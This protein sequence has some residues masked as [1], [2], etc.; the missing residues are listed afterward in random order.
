VNKVHLDDFQQNLEKDL[1][2]IAGPKKS[3]L[4]SEFQPGNLVFP[5]IIPRRK[6]QTADGQAR[7]RHQRRRTENNTQSMNNSYY[8]PKGLDSL[9]VSQISM[10]KEISVD[11]LVQ[12][13][14]VV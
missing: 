8:I 5:S 3:P 13:A 9:N 14:S 12:N 6:S 10:K 4:S 2:I 11:R 7:P 1:P